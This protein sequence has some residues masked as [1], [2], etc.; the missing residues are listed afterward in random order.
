MAASP[1]L[2]EE[3]DREGIAEAM[4]ALEAAKAGTDHS[5]IHAGVEALD[6][7]SKGFAQR[8]MDRALAQGLRGRG[9]DEVESKVARR[10]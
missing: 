4:R 3:G 2:L 1:E 9:V 10:P 5:R 8:R 6:A 7:A